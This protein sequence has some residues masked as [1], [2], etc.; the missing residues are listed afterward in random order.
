MFNLYLRKPKSLGAGIKR[1]KRWLGVSGKAKN[2]APNKKGERMY[3]NSRNYTEISI[4][5]ENDLLSISRNLS[6]HKSDPYML[7]V[8]NGKIKCVSRE[9]N[10]NNPVAHIRLTTR[11]DYVIQDGRIDATPPRRIKHTICPK[12][13]RINAGG[14]RV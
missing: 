13:G 4:K 6:F 9:Y 11:S 1:V 3:S 8:L 2:I 14:L 7:R 10:N 12:P 5:S